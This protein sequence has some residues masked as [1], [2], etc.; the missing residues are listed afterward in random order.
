MILDPVDYAIISQALIAAAREMGVKLVRSAFSTVLREARDGSAALLDARGNT[1][2]QAELIP[3]Q[4][5]TIGH[6]FQPCAELYPVETL[7][8]GDF[9][10][11]NDPY[12]GGQH[13]Q[14]VFLFH[15]I[16]HRGRVLG[17]SA[18]VAHHLDL[19]GGSPGLNALATDVWSEGLII[20]P[21]K[22]NMA[23]DWHGGMFER[24]LRANVRVPHQ[25]MGDFDAQ[26]A[27]NAIGMSR[28]EELADRYGAEMVLAVMAALQDYSEVRMRA[29][30]RA[31][32]DGVYAGEDAVDDD[33]ESDAPLPVR[34]TVTVHD[35]TIAV[36][37]TGTAP[38]VRRNL[39]APF[40]STMSA[41]LSCVKAVLT[42]PDIP[43]N[44]GAARPVTITAPRGSLLNPN[45]P[46]PVRARME[47][48]FRAWNAV[49]KALAQAVPDR[50]I[51][52]GFDT[53]TVSVLS[54]LKRDGWS[55]YLEINGGGYGASAAADGCDAVDGPLSNCSNTPV[56]ALDQDFDFFR[57]TEYSLHSDSC[58]EGAQRGGL[59]FLR[60]CEILSDDVS[61]ALYSDR[62]RRAPDGMAGGGPGSTGYCEIK[63]GGQSIRLRSKD[64]TRLQKGD[65]VTLALGGGG[66]YGAPSARPAGSLEADVA[67][68]LV[69][70]AKA[71]RWGANSPTDA[72][73]RGCARR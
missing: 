72:N 19:G 53:T 35:D 38:Q 31:V 40:A 7:Q 20:P 63:R 47:A 71:A 34:A 55:V 30:I 22:L 57:V 70:P 68:G 64:E 8:P 2:A 21:L 6:I 39:N 42:S 45:R 49:M 43:F 44:A 17:F 54:H 32:P 46:A 61:I 23:R 3:M 73:S 13:L 29:A 66:G 60:R 24:L 1:V 4:L 51:A 18:S 28:I 33:G 27:A 50:A 10:A 25:T 58:G 5:G 59:G 41:A 16:F 14:D 56:E 15:P 12:S 37:F 65:I 26:M 9:F 62:F 11:I 52:C 69:T 48:C 67:D 36:D